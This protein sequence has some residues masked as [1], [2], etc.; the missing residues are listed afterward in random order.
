MRG[1]IMRVGR[2]SARFAVRFGKGLVLVAR[3][4]SAGAG[5]LRRRF[6]I[7]I[8]LISAGVPLASAQVASNGAA[9]VTFT[10]DFPQSDPP[11]YA[12]S[13]DSAGHANFECTVKA[14]KEGED[15]SYHAEFEVSH[16]TLNHIFQLAKQA[17]FFEGKIDS[18]NRKLAF[19]GDKILSYQDGQKSLTQRFNYSNLEPV[20]DLTAL[21][22][23]MEEMLDYG[24]KLVYL[25]KY[26]KLGLDEELKRMEEQARRSELTETQVVAPVLQEIV[27]DPSVM[28]VSRARARELIDMG[29]IEKGKD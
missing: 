26:Q 24:R 11:H 14:E 1:A 28:N 10:L 29:K 17:R 27:D 16:V 19:T 6:I 23:N 22:Q 25:H 8:V 2:L 9:Q 13:V 4:A 18:G 3:S 20:R 12:I 7:S 15:E 21:F 5:F